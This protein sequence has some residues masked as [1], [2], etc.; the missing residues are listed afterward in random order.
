MLT[1]KLNPSAKTQ[2][3]GIVVA[4]R[5]EEVLFK[6]GGALHCGGNDINLFDCFNEYAE[7]LSSEAKEDLFECFQD[8]KMILDPQS[9]EEGNPPPEELMLN[10]HKYH[11]LVAKLEPILI[12]MIDLIRPLNYEYFIVQN[13]FA[14]PP[15]N[16]D[17]YYSRGEFPA[18]TTINA[19]SYRDLAKFTLVMRPIFPIISEM[20][21]KAEEIAGKDYKDVVTGNLITGIP[22][23]MNH[24]GWKKLVEYVEYSYSA[25]GRT[26][27]PLRLEIISE[28]RYANHAV[29]KALFSRLCLSHIPSQLPTK[30]LA[31]S[32]YSIVRQFDAIQTQIRDKK[33]TGMD[34]SNQKRSMYEIYQLKENVNAADE[35]AQAE[36][37]SFGLMD[38]NDKPR[39][40]D[41]FKYQC[42][43]LGIESEQVVDAL[44]ELIPDNWR[45]ELCP[46]MV[47][48]LQLAFADDISYN[49]V[50]ALEYRQLMPAL[51]LAQAKLHQMG[52]VNLSVLM[53]AIPDP[54]EDRT[55]TESIY[56]L[57]SDERKS[58]E[59]LCDVVKGKGDTTSDNEAVAAAMEFFND[60]GKHAWQ[61]TIEPGM[62]GDEEAMRT[63]VRGRL[64][65]VEINREIKEEFL[66]LIAQ[67]N[68]L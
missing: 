6:G 57:S 24:P 63:A 38:E 22:F 48:L 66:T 62:I 19:D 39:L 33:P 1:I 60:L 35:S 42:M 25:R 3:N 49:I 18:E 45:F 32:L 58:I 65:K 15:P 50:H 27:N 2:Y 23:L 64:H 43:G 16:L 40:M 10:N 30:N 9:D 17:T 67:V 34:E 12:K 5:G 52:F 29:F 54:E 28:D 4:F 11:Y 26:I 59:S 20:L 41:R 13:G 46:H 21:D 56:S 44:Y 68:A 37:F 53:T 7:S 55:S 61:S 8:A 31:K 51:A 47:K 14:E 36:Y